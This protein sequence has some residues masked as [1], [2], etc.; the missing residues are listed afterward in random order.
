MPI[1]IDDHKKFWDEVVRPEYNE[2]MADVGDI[3]RAWHCATSL[4]HLADWVY[5]NN[6]AYIDA[7]VTYTDKNGVLKRVRNEK[8][9]ANAV[10]SLCPEFELIRGIANSAK[11]HTLER[12]ANHDAAPSHAA[13]TYTQSSSFTP[14]SFAP[15]PFGGTE[16]VML[17]GPNGD[18]IDFSLIATKALNA[19]IKFCKDHRFALE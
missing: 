2:Y 12:K 11:H 8:S 10:G 3:R 18:D 9:F 13:N 7:N 5:H 19:W 15:G 1:K 14:G 6:K 4:F 16:Q 17:E